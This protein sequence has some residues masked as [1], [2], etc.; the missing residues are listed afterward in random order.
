MIRSSA[1]RIPFRYAAG[2]AGSRF[3]A[4]LRDEQ[5]ILGARCAACARVLVPL[6]AFCSA[7]GNGTL[8][9][10]EVGP[11]GVVQSWTERADGTAFALVKLDGAD[12]AL[13]HRLLDAA[14]V[15]RCGLRV[16][17]RFAAERRGGMLDI[18]GFE[19]E[20]GGAA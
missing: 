8:E 2:T 17:A 9:E 1:I 16:R 11:G 4:A 13:V 19:P 3:L 14:G 20:Q 12:T 6:R 15:A 5:R 7:C 18:A 10:V